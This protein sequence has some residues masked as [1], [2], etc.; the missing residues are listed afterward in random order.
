MDELVKM[1]AQKVGV[2]DDKARMAVELVVNHLK[3]RLPGG[4][5][6]Q[7]DSA[8]QGKGSD[9]GSALGGKLGL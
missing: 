6:G 1:V 4:L 3:G 5:G 9:V 2:S 7:I 8:L